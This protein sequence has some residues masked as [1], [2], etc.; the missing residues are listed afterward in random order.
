MGKPTVNAIVTVNG[1]THSTVTE[2]ETLFMIGS[3]DNGQ[4]VMFVAGVDNDVVYS[5]LGAIDNNEAVAEALGKVFTVVMNLD[6]EEMSENMLRMKMGV[7]AATVEHAK[8]T[9]L[10]EKA[11]LSA[12]RKVGKGMM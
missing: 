2:A 5:I 3:E 6:K 9:G 1:E 12:A 8:N 10:M 4:G 11:L 7:V